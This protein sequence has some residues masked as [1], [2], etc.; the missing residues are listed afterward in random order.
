[1]HT[2]AHAFQN[3]YRTAAKWVRMLCRFER[4]SV[5]LAKNVW[6]VEIQPRD[7]V[8]QLARGAWTATTIPIKM[9]ADDLHDGGVFKILRPAWKHKRKIFKVSLSGNLCTVV[10]LCRGIKVC[11]RKEERRQTQTFIARSEGCTWDF[12][13]SAKSCTCGVML[14]C[15]FR[16]KNQSR[17]RIPW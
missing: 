7:L 3:G 8:A 2:P 6:L 1:M 13:V 9:A 11:T 5:S 12:L 4:E 15:R 16:K 14:I 10:F 17:W